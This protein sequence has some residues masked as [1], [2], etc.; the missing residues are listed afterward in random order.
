MAN[1]WLAGGLPA[2]ELAAKQVTGA[3]PSRPATAGADAPTR[4][5]LHP[6]AAV[7]HPLV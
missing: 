7:L 3:T 1:E 5:A 2:S 6:C 4:R